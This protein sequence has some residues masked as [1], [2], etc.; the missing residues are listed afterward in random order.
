MTE[1][2]K[3]QEG[4]ESFVETD[5]DHWMKQLEQ[6][7][8]DLNRPSPVETNPPLLQI[9]TIDWNAILNIS[10]PSGTRQNYTS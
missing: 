7:K 1:A 6:I 3:E 2:L 8:I 10:F 9:Q 4:S 5:I